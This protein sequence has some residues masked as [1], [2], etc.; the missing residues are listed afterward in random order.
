MAT[1]LIELEDGTLVEAEVP[2]D[3][4]QPIGGG[5]AKKVDET[6]DKIRPLLVKTCRPIAAALNEINK[7][8]NIEQA[9][10]ELGFGFEGEGNIYVTK[11]KVGTNLTVKLVLRPKE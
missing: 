10:V 2:P 3:Q 8:L 9:E 7:E 5:F 4:A 6:F 1:Q 11:S